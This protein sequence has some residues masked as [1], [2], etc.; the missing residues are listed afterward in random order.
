MKETSI[1]RILTELNVT[2][3]CFFIDW[4][5]YIILVVNIVFIYLKLSTLEYNVNKC[6]ITYIKE[7]K[8]KHTKTLNIYVQLP[9]Y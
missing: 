2:I 4:T 6:F 9:T 5:E 1:V 7:N 3:L 8:K